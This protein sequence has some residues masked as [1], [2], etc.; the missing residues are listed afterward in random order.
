VTLAEIVLTEHGIPFNHVHFVEFQQLFRKSIG[1]ES[2][3]TN[4]PKKKPLIRQAGSAEAFLDS[5]TTGR[6]RSQ[7]RFRHCRCQPF[8][9]E[10][11]DQWSNGA[12]GVNERW[13]GRSE[14]AEA[15]GLSRRRTSDAPSTMV[16]EAVSQAIDSGPQT[17]VFHSLEYLGC[18]EVRPTKKAMP[19]SRQSL[20]FQSGSSGVRLSRS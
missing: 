5:A 7:G 8:G 18:V 20:R 15:P 17:Q 2:H 11:T 19:V 6:E 12:L 3:P 1:I 9:A 14:K 13:V 10:T 4:H 16:D